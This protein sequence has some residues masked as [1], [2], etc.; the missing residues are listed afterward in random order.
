MKALYL[1]FTVTDFVC[2]GVNVAS[3]AYGWA[4][5]YGLAGLIMMHSFVELES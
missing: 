5:F 4:A 2:V 3:G 1:F